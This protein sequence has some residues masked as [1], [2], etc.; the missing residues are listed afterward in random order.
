[1]RAAVAAF[2]LGALAAAL[3]FVVVPMLAPAPPRQTATTRP[4]GA[5]RPAPPGDEASVRAAVTEAVQ[6]ARR[7]HGRAALE[8]DARLDELVGK[9]AQV[10]AQRAE[11]QPDRQNWLLDKDTKWLS[12]SL[13][14]ADGIGIMLLAGNS[15][16]E[17]AREIADADHVLDPEWRHLAVAARRIR[18]GEPTE[19]L[20][21][22]VLARILPAIDE[23]PLNAGER[24]FALHCRHCGEH[25][26][27][28]IPD[29]GPSERGTITLRCR[30]CG[31]LSQFFGIDTKGQYHHPPWFLT[32]H[33]TERVSDPVDAWLTVLTT[34]RYADD[35]G[36]FGY[37]DAWQQPEETRSRGL[38]DCED[39]AILL[40]DWLI[41]DGYDARVVLGTVDGGG[42][43]W[44]V[45]RDETA[46]YVLETTGGPANFMRVPPRAALMTDFTAEAQFNRGTVWYSRRITWVPTYSDPRRWLEVQE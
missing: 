45:L 31:R 41:A 21:L 7:E 1:M 30:E 27:L 43:A 38:G 8:A 14:D 16:A 33:S 24:R 10:V 23:V 22:V 3:L 42:H 6:R 44:V 25:F 32:G 15:A 2:V 40:A 20:V 34:I 39:T 12:E 35:V 19:W 26:L 28:E 18:F 37:G 17:L 36:L 13:G 29:N 46:E 9:R 5:K 11:R 4:T